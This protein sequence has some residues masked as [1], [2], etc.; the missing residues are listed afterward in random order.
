MKLKGFS[1][2]VAALTVVWRGEMTV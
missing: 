2:G 1:S